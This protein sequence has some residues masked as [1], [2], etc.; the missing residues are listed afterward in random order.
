MWHILEKS[1][2]F[3]IFLVKCAIILEWEKCVLNPHQ[4]EIG[5]KIRKADYGQQRF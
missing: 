5:D 2:T 1:K 3:F 4:I